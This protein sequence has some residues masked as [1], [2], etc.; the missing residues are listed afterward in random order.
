MNKRILI[1][2]A[3]AG[4][5]K[6]SAR[7]LALLESTEKIYLACRNEDKAKAAKKE[8]EE[9]TGKSVFEIVLMDVSNLKSVQS[10]VKSLRDPIDALIMNAGGMG[11]RTPNAKTEDGVTHIAASNVLGH[12]ELLDELLN[13]KKLTKV[14]LFAGTEA[15]RGVPKMGMKKP[16][17]STY[18]ADEFATI[19]NGSFFEE[20][21]NPMVS[22]GPVKFTA[23]LSLMSIARKNPDV[24]IISMSPGGTSGTDAANSLS[25]FMKFLFKF[26]GTTLMPLM[27]LMHKLEIGAKRYVD[28]ITNETFKSGVFYAS[29]AK[30]TIGPVVDQ[31]TIFPDFNNTVYQDNAY[32]AIRSFIK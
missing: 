25:F 17:L 32:E 5:G 29:K 20:N 7:Q 28:G 15:A 11:G 31:A 18:S 19:L 12:I 23:I 1:T 27:G 22:Y 30:V 9:S 24:R 8:L 14:A 21:V 13:A 4:L 6:E 16:E 26:M 3:N 2:G 10:A